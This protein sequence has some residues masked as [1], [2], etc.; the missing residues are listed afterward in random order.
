MALAPPIRATLVPRRRRRSRRLRRDPH[1]V[2][3][4]ANLCVL[5]KLA[6]N[7]TS[8]GLVPL[9]RLDGGLEQSTV[10]TGVRGGSDARLMGF[11]RADEKKAFRHMPCVWV[12]APTPGAA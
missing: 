12:D 2:D 4:T 7:T 6:R 11:T 1:L 9:W 10:A 8:N 3:A 5:F